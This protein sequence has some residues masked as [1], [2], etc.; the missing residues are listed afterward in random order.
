MTHARPNLSRP[1]PDRPNLTRPNRSRANLY[2]PNR[3]RANLSRPNPDRRRPTPL[4]AGAAR[5]LAQLAATVTA[6]TIAAV[7]LVGAAA[8]AAAHDSPH[9][10]SRCALSG[11]TAVVH[12]RVYSCT[13][14]AKRPRWDTGRPITTTRL[15]LT[16]AWVKAAPR[17]A[18]SALFGTLT[19][20]TNAPIRVI[21]AMSPVAPALQLHEVVLQDG[22]SVMQQ[23]S[24]GFVVP[25]GGTVTLAPG[26][27]HI[28]LLDLRRALAA[29]STV[30]VTLVTADGGLVTVRPIVRVFHGANES[31][32]GAMAR[33]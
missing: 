26:G 16:D 19:N 14:P 8:P 30:P 25:A 29:G 2:R 7:A 20:P 33:H 22:Q 3:S 21:A 5:L 27:N 10:G 1:N 11:M 18:M 4:R 17:T 9:A 24:G 23:K 13:D 12:G 31:Y 28:M 32:P 6:A 15:R